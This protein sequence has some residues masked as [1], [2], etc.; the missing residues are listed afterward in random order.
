MRYNL[1]VK[2]ENR[3]DREEYLTAVAQA[4]KWAE[5]YYDND[6]PSVTDFEYDMLMQKIKKAE[7]EH[8]EWV[9]ELSPTQHVGGSAGKS[10]FEKVEHA[11]PMLSIQD[12][13]SEEEVEEFIGQYPNETFSVEKKIDGLSLSVTYRGGVYIRGETRGDGRVGEDITEN[14]RHIIGIPEKL[15]LKGSGG[16]GLLEVRCEVYMPVSEFERVNQEQAAAGKKLFANPR[17]AAAGILRTK[18]VAVVKA[19]K[20]HAFAFNIQR[21]E[22]LPDAGDNIFETTSHLETLRIIH[23]LGFDIVDAYAAKGKEVFQCIQKIGDSRDGL[24]YWV[25]GAVVKIDDLQLRERL[26]NTVKFPRWCVA[27]KYPPEERDTIV[28]EIKVQAGRT[29]VLTPVAVFE[30]LQLCG[31]TVTRATLHNQGFIDSM[32]IDVGSTIRVIKSGEIIP[33]VI[34]AVKPAPKPYKIG[35]CPACG[36]TAV[37][38]TDENGEETGVAGCPNEAC[39]AKFS[40]YVEFFCSR[41]VMD[42]G[43]MGPA[44]IDKLIDIGAVEEIQDLYY[45]DRHSDQIKAL[46][47]FGDKKLRSML[48]NIEK[49][50]ANDIDRVIKAFGIQGVGRVTGKALAERYPDMEAISKLEESELM[51]IDGIGDITAH[52]IYTFF[53][54][55]D[56]LARYHAL[57]DAGVNMKSLIYGKNAGDGK[58]SGLTFVITGTLP[59]MG[60]EEAKALIETNGGKCA[61]SVSK[62]TNYLLAGE[63]AGSKLTKAHDLGIPVITEQELMEMIK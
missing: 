32:C 27:F 37:M 8:P 50:K 30:P 38:L 48:E 44:V 42:I 18:D 62:K 54:S 22:P 35:K 63:A 24:A 3:M 58:L 53:H 45:L 46:D 36:A 4:A 1:K 43:G 11:V 57:A 21:Y 60:R 17:N 15:K 19:A 51:A 2:E 34:K 16:M 9:V 29:G 56:G 14:A 33:K 40:K 13:F 39:P 59:S 25:D 47:G 10:T 61:G 20:L 5:E 55:E 23:E 31:T 49:S 26:G 6:E 28:K 52:D 41:D 7:K 12:V